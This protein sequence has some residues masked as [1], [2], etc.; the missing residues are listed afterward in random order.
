MRRV[1]LLALSATALQAPRA[2]TKRC[3]RTRRH[4]GAAEV[5][6]D[7][8]T[9][10]EANPLPVKMAT[11]TCIIGA[12]DA[13]AQAIEGLKTSSPLDGGRVARWAFFGF[14]L[15]APWN[16]AFQNALEAAIPST[17]D[18]WTATTALKV[19]ID[20]GVQAPVFTALIFLFFAVIEGRG[21][22]AGVDQLRAE[23]APTLLK[24]WLVF[25]PA[26]VVNLGLVPL[27]L[28]VLFINVV[29]FFWV[30][31]LSLVINAKEVS[32]V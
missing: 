22:S 26:T 23:L 17:P 8:L 30:I 20:Q 29:F 18:P 16:H 27:E 14:V 24:N 31:F 9:A 19:G 7:Y 2:P 21:V 3:R 5:W 6:A 32:E 12:G 4:L 11:A 13:A 10:L 15:Q 1:A 25:V 28:R